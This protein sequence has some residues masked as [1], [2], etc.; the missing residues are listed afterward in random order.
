VKA[1]I[2]MTVTVVAAA[3]RKEKAQEQYKTQCQR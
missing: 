3:S 2:A 1:R